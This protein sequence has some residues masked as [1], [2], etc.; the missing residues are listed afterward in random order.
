[1]PPHN[2]SVR[3]D[4]VSNTQVAPV[5]NSAVR[6]KDDGELEVQIHTL[7]NSAVGGVET[8]GQLHAPAERERPSAGLDGV[9][10]KKNLCNCRE[11]NPNSSV[12]QPIP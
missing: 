5:I 9:I 11:T 1:M 3:F 8:S 4:P 12:F 2:S 6:N 10:E 7:L